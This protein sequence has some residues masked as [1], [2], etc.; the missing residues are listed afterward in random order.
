MIRH[1]YIKNCRLKSR[2]SLRARNLG[3]RN[4][5]LGIFWMTVSNGV[6]MSRLNQPAL[7]FSV[8][9][10]RAKLPSL[11]NYLAERFQH[12]QCEFRTLRE[13]TIYKKEPG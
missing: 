1:L 12:N 2:L 7:S 5:N 3:H 9:T 4:V 8:E 13:R 10:D 11:F 6:I